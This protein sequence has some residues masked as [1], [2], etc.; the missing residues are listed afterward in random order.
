MNIGNAGRFAVLFSAVL[1]L[2]GCDGSSSQAKRQP[3]VPIVAGDQCAVCGM[4]ITEYPGPRGEAYIQGSATPLKFGSTRDFFAYVLQPEHEALLQTLYVQDMA[5]TSWDHPKD[6]WIDARKAWY[7]PES[8]LPSAMGP[9]LASFRNKADAEKFA[10]RYHGKVLSYGEV[11][12]DLIT[13]L[14]A[15]KMDM[16]LMPKEKMDMKSMPK[17]M[18]TMPMSPQ[19]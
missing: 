13:S 17:D 6:H 1:L 8:A 5:A 12:V 15:P 11:T 16:K 18:K 19:R 2:A 4:Y 3:P 9:T 14:P 7:V 10:Q